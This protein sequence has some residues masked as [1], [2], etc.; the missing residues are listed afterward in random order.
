MKALKKEIQAATTRDPMRSDLDGFMRCGVEVCPANLAKVRAIER[1]LR[2]RAK[3]PNGVTPELAVLWL[4][5]AREKDPD[6]A[7][8]F[9]GDY[10]DIEHDPDALARLCET[11][12]HYLAT[13]RH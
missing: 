7:R 4:L 6:A 3:Q 5:F 13:A 10:S 8:H 2:A 12:A 1:V 9:D 11:L